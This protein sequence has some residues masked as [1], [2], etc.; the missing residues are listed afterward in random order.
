MDTEGSE[1][2]AYE[3]CVI[4]LNKICIETIKQTPFSGTFQ[5]NDAVRD[6]H[7]HEAPGREGEGTSRP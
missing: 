4:L 3:M 2:T 1:V 6:L 7:L 5:P